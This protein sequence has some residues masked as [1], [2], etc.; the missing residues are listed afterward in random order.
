[1][2]LL[3]FLLFFICYSVASVGQS[4]LIEKDGFLYTN[5]ILYSEKDIPVLS[6]IDTGCSLCVIDSTF[7]SKNIVIN[8]LDS[9][10]VLINSNNYKVSF[11]V[12]D[13]LFFCGKKIG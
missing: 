4:S 12:I 10:Y 7:V 13:S 1:M 3:F 6:L 11:C 5:T 2:K 8:S 9:N